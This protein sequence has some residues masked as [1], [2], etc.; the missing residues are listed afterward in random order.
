MKSKRDVDNHVRELDRLQYAWFRHWL[1]CFQ[2]RL[3]TEGGVRDRSH[4]ELRHYA[5]NPLRF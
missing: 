2:D 1:S 4:H 3:Y 5:S